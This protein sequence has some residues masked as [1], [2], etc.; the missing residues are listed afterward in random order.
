MVEKV[1]L[2]GLVDG[3]V[4]VV[5]VVV[6][7]ALVAVVAA[8]EGASAVVVGTLAPKPLPDL[9]TAGEWGR[10]AHPDEVT[11]TRP[12]NLKKSCI[13]RLL[14]GPHTQ[15]RP[16]TAFFQEEQTRVDRRNT[17]AWKA[18]EGVEEEQGRRRVEGS[19]ACGRRRGGGRGGGW[20]ARAK[21]RKRA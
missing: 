3:V 16:Q 4:V 18:R 13:R 20:R 8:G 11:R 1:P 2:L 12:T 17:A 5:V 6:A 21:K 15:V 19:S 10:A 9:S 7:A 14:S